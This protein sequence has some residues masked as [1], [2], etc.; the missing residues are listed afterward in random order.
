MLAAALVVTLSACGDHRAPASPA[1]SNRDRVMPAALTVA[2]T[3]APLGANHP[4]APWLKQHFA[5]F[6][7][8]WHTR[9]MSLSH[10]MFEEAFAWRHLGLNFAQARFV[11]TGTGLPGGPPGESGV[12]VVPGTR[13]V[14]VM[15]GPGV[16][17]TCSGRGEPAPPDSGGF[18]F[19]AGDSHARHVVYGG[20]VPDGNRSVSIVLANGTTKT[21]PVVANVYSITVKGRAVTLTDKDAAGHLEKFRLSLKVS[22]F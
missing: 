3:T 10:L 8:S 17:G 11:H 12:W 13:G 15:N 5:I 19:V 6:R 20:L 4:I 22:E 18:R 1:P 7:T 9:P 2:N 21:V 14:C 16:G